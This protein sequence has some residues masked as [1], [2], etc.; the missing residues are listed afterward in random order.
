MR[1]TPRPTREEVAIIVLAIVVAV[2]GGYH[3]GLWV[4]KESS[5]Y[6]YP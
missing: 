3:Y 4:N 2:L 5:Y 6:G 1:L